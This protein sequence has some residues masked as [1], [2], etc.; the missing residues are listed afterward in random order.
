MGTC[1]ADLL[2]TAG[3]PGMTDCCNRCHQLVQLITRGM[4]PR[5]VLGHIVHFV[6]GSISKSASPR[7]QDVH[8]PLFSDAYCPALQSKHFPLFAWPFLTYLPAHTNCDERFHTTHLQI[9]G[10]ARSHLR[11]NRT[12]DSTSVAGVLDKNLPAGHAVQL[13]D[14][15][16]EVVPAPQ[17]LHMVS[18]TLSPSYLR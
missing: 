14:H 13:V 1:S 9:T 2:R 10:K 5:A 11:Q 8:E 4:V 6:A 16:S 15:F 3:P 7:A 18:G 17:R 12:G